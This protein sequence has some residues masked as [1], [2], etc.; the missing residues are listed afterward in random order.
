MGE[1]PKKQ[2]MI[3]VEYADGQVVYD[4]V[5]PSGLFKT[6]MVVEGKEVVSRREITMEEFA[7]EMKL[8]REGA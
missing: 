4:G 5:S 3:R 1:Q 8:K 7:E 6:M 2:S